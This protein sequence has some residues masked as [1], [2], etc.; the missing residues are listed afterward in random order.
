M[1]TYFSPSRVEEITVSLAI[2]LANGQGEHVRKMT[3]SEAIN[4]RE[5]LNQLADLLLSACDLAA[6]KLKPNIEAQRIDLKA[7][8]DY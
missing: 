2:K 3:F 8:H 4:E 6:S 5:T 1:A 7:G